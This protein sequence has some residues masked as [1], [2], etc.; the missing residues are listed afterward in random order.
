MLSDDYRDILSA[1][2]KKKVKFLLVGTYAM[3]VHG[4]PRATMDI[5]IL[6]AFETENVQAVIN[7]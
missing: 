2:S 4:Y 3:A 1:L 7:A 6:I 5:D